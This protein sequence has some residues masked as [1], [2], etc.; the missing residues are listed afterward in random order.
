MRWLDGITNSMDMSLRKF[1][2]MVKDRQACVLQSRGLQ[3]VG[4]NSVTEQQQGGKNTLTGMQLL[5]IPLQ[6]WLQAAQ[7][8]F[9]VSLPGVEIQG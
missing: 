4:H 1:W 5:L 3:R 2:E 8:P 9:T 6:P 7:E